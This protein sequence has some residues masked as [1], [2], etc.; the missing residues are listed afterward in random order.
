MH[1]EETGSVEREGGGGAAG[2]EERQ[3]RQ[4]TMAAPL[5]L[6]FFSEALFIHYPA[7]VPN[8]PGIFSLTLTLG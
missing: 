5:F 3:K 4:K 1:K 6:T 8:E 2:C 7:M